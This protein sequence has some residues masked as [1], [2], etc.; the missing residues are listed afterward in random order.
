[1]DSSP[2]MGK[3][4]LW[5]WSECPWNE[6][7]SWDNKIGGWFQFFSM[8]SKQV[9]GS[10]QQEGTMIKWKVPLAKLRSSVWH[11]SKPKIMTRKLMKYGMLSKQRRSQPWTSSLGRLDSDT[12]RFNEIL[13]SKQELF[14]T[15][16]HT[17]IIRIHQ[18]KSPVCLN[19]KIIFFW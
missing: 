1:M 11:D 2:L 12:L 7:S 10:G 8:L 14:F 3:Q 5:C 18:I 15:A 6:G 4:G 13:S 9:N 19:N 17:W 16:S